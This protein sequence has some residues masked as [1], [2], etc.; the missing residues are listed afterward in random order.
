MNTKA[1]LLAAAAAISLGASANAASN[2]WYAGLEGGGAWLDDLGGRETCTA[3]LPTRFHFD[4]STDA[5]WAI[6]GTVGYEW[7]QWRL[8]GEIGY[9]RNDMNHIS[10]RTIGSST[11]PL[12]DL[13]QFTLMANMLYDVPLGDRFS[14][15]LGAGVGF[16]RISF[17]WPIFGANGWS[18]DEWKFAWQGIAGLNYSLGPNCDIFVNYRYLSADGP[19]FRKT[20]AIFYALHFD[21]INTHTASAG[22]RWHFGT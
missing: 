9:R 16:D 15:A 13:G 19:D 4:I 7:D 11:S 22:L 18:D 10:F 12:G 5:G 20:T 14:L 17:D 21:D 1:T 6:L 3:C 2:G 8:E